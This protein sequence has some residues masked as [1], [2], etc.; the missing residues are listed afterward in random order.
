MSHN[1][2][3]FIHVNHDMQHTNTHTHNSTHVRTHT[4]STL[5]HITSH[6]KIQV[7]N[8]S[9]MPPTQRTEA[10][11]LIKLSCA[12]DYV[13]ARVWESGKRW[14]AGA[15]RRHARRHGD[16]TRGVGWQT[17]PPLLIF[18][19]MDVPSFCNFSPFLPGGGPFG[20]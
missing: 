1:K 17:I 9:H 18:T 20:E 6:I 8:E 7:E 10:L 14:S 13:T 4:Y 19:H 3:R 12:R 16:E 11:R 5:H 15:M 2:N